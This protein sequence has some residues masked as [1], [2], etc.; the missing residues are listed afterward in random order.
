MFGVG[1]SMQEFSWALVIGENFLFQRLLILPSICV[2]PF[3]S[4][5][6]KW[7]IIQ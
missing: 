3:T 6:Q 5:L 4:L 1:A 7:G 2:N